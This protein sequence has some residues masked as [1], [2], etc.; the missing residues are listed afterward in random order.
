ML[1]SAPNDRFLLREY[2]AAFIRRAISIV[3]L[4]G[5]AILGLERN[6]ASHLV[7]RDSVID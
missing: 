3:C 4:R 2:V 1:H 6:R 5:A 7:K